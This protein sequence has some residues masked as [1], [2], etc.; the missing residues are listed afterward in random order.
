[1]NL[2]Q[3]RLG[4]F[5]LCAF[6]CAFYPAQVPAAADDVALIISNQ[7]SD[8]LL[9]IRFRSNRNV[10]FVRLD[11]SPGARDEIENPGGT[12][13]LR[14]D[15]GL[16]LCIFK[17]VPI[18]Q[19][20]RL[21]FCGDHAA[22][23]ILDMRNKVSRHFSGSRQSLLPGPDSAPVCA[24]DQF[25]PG[26]TMS[27]VCGLLGSDLPRDDN[28]AVLTS[29]GFADLIWAGPSFAGPDVRSGQTIRAGS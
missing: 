14:L 5:L 11:M 23:L 8:D 12:A 27:D 13:D 7:S 22:C 24:L 18:G 9:N 25:H 10:F 3:R 21:T 6:L 29:L 20:R 19:A 1:M 15:T 4:P 16:A 17:A 2:M 26:M 28:D